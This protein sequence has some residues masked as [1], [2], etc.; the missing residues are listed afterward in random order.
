MIKWAENEKIEVFFDDTPHVSIRYA[1][2]SMSDQEIKSIKKYPFVNKKNL[3]VKITDKTHNYSYSFDIP[4][5]YCFDGA[6]VPWLFRRI[7]GAPT[8]NSFLIAALVHDVLCEHHDYIDNNR[9]LSSDVFNA[10]L[11][12]SKVNKFKRY[13]MYH[14]VNTFQALFGDWGIEYG[15]T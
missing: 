1:L 14:S 12:T 6:S 15:Q 11:E 8:D 10:L 3:K 7:I 2:P 4:K 13:L 9:Q 5:G